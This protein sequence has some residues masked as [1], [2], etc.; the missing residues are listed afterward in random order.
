MRPHPQAPRTLKRQLLKKGE[1][2]GETGDQILAW[3]GHY[4][5]VWRG[6]ALSP[7]YTEREGLRATQR[8]DPGAQGTDPEGVSSG[9]TFNDFDSPE[10]KHRATSAREHA[11]LSLIRS[12]SNCQGLGQGVMQSVPRG[13]GVLSWLFDR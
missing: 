13:S 10:G 2:D 5:A 3:L 11:L 6:Q 1:Q 9:V 12:P 7:L 8:A 4:V